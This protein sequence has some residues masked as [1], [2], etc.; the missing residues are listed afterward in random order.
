VVA[1]QLQGILVPALTHVLR[2]AKKR[3]KH[4]E[5]DSFV[6]FAFYCGNYKGAELTKPDY[7]FAI[8]NICYLFFASVLFL[9]SSGCHR[10]SVP[11]IIYIGHVASIRGPDKLSGE[12]ARQG[13][14]LALEE[15]QGSEGTINENK[16]IEVI[17]VDTGGDLK[18]VEPAAVRLVA[19]N[20]VVA[21][22][23]GT[24][25]A[26]VEAM[27]PVAQSNEV[28]LIASGGLPGK[29]LSDYFF[30]T[31]LSQDRQAEFLAN[32]AVNH[33]SPAIKKMAVLV[34]GIDKGPSS[35]LAGKFMREFLKREGNAMTGEWTYKEYRKDAKTSE[36]EWGF[37]STEELKEIIDQVRNKH[38]DAIFLAGSPVDLS[39]LLKAGLDD[40]LPL[41]FAGEEGNERALSGV[42]AGRPIFLAT[43]FALD[44]NERQKAFAT[45][46]EKRFAEPP[47]VHAAFAYENSRILL[48]VLAHA[49][50]FKGSKI[51]EGLESLTSFPT[52]TGTVS[53]DKENH[54][55]DCQAFVVR[56]QDGRV[57]V[58][59]SQE[60]G[61]KKD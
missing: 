11:E 26:Q 30:R 45:Q 12:H 16:R 31:G 43:G 58:E 57:K 2:A 29:S 17:H 7:Q 15:A 36:G 38:P 35:F 6:Y 55:A 60:G 1:P 27:I 22:L 18:A 3:K 28:P 49:T 50:S 5:L 19:V 32:F 34:D 44:Q 13:I 48:E 39:R 25:W 52:L 9:A 41:F 40:K 47:D 54:E 46:Y 53:F 24:D 51:K 42:S 59:Y 61:D 20:R 21:L 14:L 56:V 23:G 4:K 8:C 37:K 33:H 10:K